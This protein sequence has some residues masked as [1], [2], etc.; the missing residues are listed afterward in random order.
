[1]QDDLTIAFEM[2]TSMP[3]ALF[4]PSTSA[5]NLQRHRAG[6]CGLFTAAS[7]GSGTDDPGRFGVSLVHTGVAFGGGRASSN[8][9]HDTLEDPCTHNSMT[10]CRSNPSH[11]LRDPGAIVT[12]GLWHTVIATRTRATGRQ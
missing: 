8:E 7:G 11:Y 5:A 4:E 2:R 1:M 10:T 6:G 9:E 3:Y 12:D